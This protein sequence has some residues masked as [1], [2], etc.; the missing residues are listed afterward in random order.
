MNHYSQL[1][2]TSQR[3]HL[4]LHDEKGQ[5]SAGVMPVRGEEALRRLRWLWR[6]RNAGALPSVGVRTPEQFVD[7]L[8]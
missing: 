8:G 2:F 3:Q 1:A 5:R 6:V 4:K 7:C